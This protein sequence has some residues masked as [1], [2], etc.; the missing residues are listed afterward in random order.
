MAHSARRTELVT[1]T[2]SSASV[3][4]KRL[5]CLPTAPNNSDKPGTTTIEPPINKVRCPLSAPGTA[6]RH[7][8][9]VRTKISLL[10]DFALAQIHDVEL[11]IL[12]SLAGESRQIGL[13]HP[14]MTA[15]RPHAF[16]VFNAVRARPGARKASSQDSHPLRALVSNYGFACPS[17]RLGCRSARA[18]LTGLLRFHVFLQ[19]RLL[20]IFFVKNVRE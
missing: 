12:M 13:R 14:V 3:V 20:G 6:D 18:F 2:E 10:H 19:I 11:G 5:I 15:R 1:C 17:L 9:C 8:K 16:T 7:T 4:S